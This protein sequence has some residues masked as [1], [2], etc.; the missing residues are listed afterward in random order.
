MKKNRLLTVFALLLFVS[1]AIFYGC[2]KSDL[3]ETKE[4]TNLVEFYKQKLKDQTTSVTQVV[5]LP[6]KG[7]Y[8]DINGNRIT[9]IM[10]KGN[11]TEATSCPG[12]GDSEFVNDL[13]SITT[14]Y[15][16]NVGYRFLVT[17]KLT[18]EF[19]PQMTNGG[20]LLSRGRIKLLNGSTQVYIT[21]TSTVNPVLTIQNNGVVY[22]NSNGDDMNE[23]II[24]YRSEIISEAT[25]NSATSIQCNLTCYTDCPDYATLN[26]PFSTNQSIP[27]SQQTS[28]PCLRIDKVWF[29]PSSGGVPANLAGCDPV[30]SGCFPWGYVY[31]EKQEVE[32]KN[33]SGVWKKFY[34]HINGLGQ[35]GVETG[36]INFWDLWYIDVSLSQSNNGLVPGNVQVRYRNKQVTNGLNGGPCV[37]QPDGTYVTETWYIN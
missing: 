11:G 17:Y 12:S 9:L 35:A 23:F 33:G 32:F 18:S 4:Q 27:A 34:L 20:S 2:K 37:T 15:T 29:N 31:P 10:G 24:T 7:Y 8:G 36:L 16:C 30:G 26:I 3:N 21:P 14:E 25:F 28:L 22:L 5:N 13:V 19:Y 1:L 6:G